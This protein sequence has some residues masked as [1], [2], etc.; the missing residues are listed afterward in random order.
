MTSPEPTAGS[1]VGFLETGS[2]AKGIEA[3]SPSG[4]KGLQ[5]LAGEVGAVRVAIAAGMPP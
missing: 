4:G 5:V 3:C 1:S 2:I